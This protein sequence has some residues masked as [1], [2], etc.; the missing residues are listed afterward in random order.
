MQ[1]SNKEWWAHHWYDIDKIQ[2]V[3]DLEAKRRKEIMDVVDNHHIIGK[4][5]G[6]TDHSRNQKDILRRM[7]VAHNEIFWD[8]LPHEQIEATAEFSSPVYSKHMSEVL[9]Q[10]QDSFR[11]LW[12]SE[13]MYI[14][15]CWNGTEWLLKRNRFA[16]KPKP[17]SFSSHD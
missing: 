1:L 6:G 12:L 9:G 10:L 16:M 14:R 17:H 13:R 11:T 3:L 15:T 8:D 4:A 2:P 7:H 5:N